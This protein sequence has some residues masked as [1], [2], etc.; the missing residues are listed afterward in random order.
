MDYQT[1]TRY[2]IWSEEHGGWWRAARR[3]YTTEMREAGV[4]TAPEA[5]EIVEQ[6]NLMGVFHEVAIPL[7]DDLDDLKTRSTP[8]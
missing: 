8:R 4:Y 5:R 1:Y 7:P 2:L 6:G 3:G